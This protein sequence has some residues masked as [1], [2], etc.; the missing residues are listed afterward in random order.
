[1]SHYVNSVRQH[2]SSHI[3]LGLSFSSENLC[4]TGILCQATKIPEFYYYR[5][6]TERLKTL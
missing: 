1:M 6:V 5:I 2:T 4:S 3:Y